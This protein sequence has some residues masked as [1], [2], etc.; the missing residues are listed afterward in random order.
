MEP[1]ATFDAH[2]KHACALKFSPDGRELFT[3]GMDALA[4]RW[5]VASWSQT[6][7]LTGHDNSVNCLAFSPD[8]QRV[9][10]GSTDATVRVW[11]LRTNALVATLTGHK[12]TVVTLAFSPDGALL[13]SGSYDATVRLWDARENTA[14]ASLKGHKKN[15]TAVCFTHDGATL[16]S[17]ALG[18]DLRR[19]HIPSG[20]PAGLLQADPIVAWGLRLLPDGAHMTLVSHQRGVHL[21]STDDWTLSQPIPLG[22]PTGLQGLAL[23]RDGARLALTRPHHVSVW[24]ITGATPLHTWEGGPKGLYGADFSPDGA[25]LAVAAAD[26]RVRV[27]AV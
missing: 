26:G 23:S 1:I 9:A 8:G 12:K 13:A 22:P 2:A 6:A 16:V 7:A 27:F 3:G 5:D 20:E 21:L 24:P 17:A 11:D 25:L 4:K 10:T 14:R 15:V 18:G 19:W